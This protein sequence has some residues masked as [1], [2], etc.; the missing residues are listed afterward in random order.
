MVIVSVQFLEGFDDLNVI[1]SRVVCLNFF[2]TF[3]GGGG[4]KKNLGC[5][6]SR[7]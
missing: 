5:S 1:S 2:L 6:T 7:R 3:P 4:K